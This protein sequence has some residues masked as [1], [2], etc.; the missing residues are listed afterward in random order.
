MGPSA[1]LFLSV[2]CCA[3]RAQSGGDSAAPGKLSPEEVA[4]RVG[5][6]LSQDPQFPAWYV[7]RRVRFIEQS[8]ALRNSG[9]ATPEQV[10]S[11][12]RYFKDCL[13]QWNVINELRVTPP[14]P[15]HD[16]LAARE[17]RLTKVIEKD[18]D[19][20]GDIEPALYHTGH[21]KK[22]DPEAPSAPPTETPI[23]AVN[24]DGHVVAPTPEVVSPQTSGVTTNSNDSDAVADPLQT[25]NKA[26]FDLKHGMTAGAASAY[27]Q[28]LASDPANSAA[29]SGLSS[30]LFKEGNFT[31]AADAAAQALKLDPS[32]Q[33]ALAV[34]HLS[35]DRTSPPLAAAAPAFGDQGAA[36][37]VPTGAVSARAAA[38]AAVA[39]SGA[40]PG[41]SS[42]SA[43]REARTAVGL[44]DL[45][46]ALSIL[47]RALDRRPDDAALLAARAQVCVLRREYARAEADARAALASAP[48]DAGAL[49]A[50]GLS[51]L[52][53][54][55]YAGADETAEALITFHPRDAFGYALRA[56]ARGSAGDRAGMLADLKRAAALDPYYAPALARL[57]APLE[58]PTERDLLFLF[59]GEPERRPAPPSPRGRGYAVPLAL[60]AG[61][62]LGALLA[63]ALLSLKRKPAPK[64]APPLFTRREGA[65]GGAAGAVAGPASPVLIAGQYE[66]SRQIGEGGM[67]TVYSGVD[68]LLK[69]P[70]AIKKMREELRHNPQ[71]RARFVIEAK[72]V[73]ALH[74]PAIVDIY[75]IAE[76]GP[77]LYLI[78]E[79]ID[80]KTV[81]ELV[82]AE[83]R[84]SLAET[85]RATRAA[86]DALDFAHAHG[87]VHRDM[88]P[89]NMMRDASGRVKVMDFGIARMVKDSLTR[90]SMTNNVIGTPPYMAPE[91]EQGHVRRE[92]DVYA[93]A[94]CAYEMTTGKLPFLGV[95][96]G[97]LMNKLRMSYV[98]PSRAIAGLPEALDAVYA[99]A[100]QADPDRRCRTPKEFADALESVPSGAARTRRATP[101]NLAP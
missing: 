49:R 74:H 95:G 100:F 81:H 22:V 3:A 16:A 1:Y 92:S 44:K 53:L 82:Q 36:G 84:L 31:A 12:V 46:S 76:H 91:Q 23:P 51:Q 77:D 80:G 47:D 41:G 59:P 55:D 63:L 97:M 19:G 26:N 29:L 54:K 6:E 94:V 89:S 45:D 15:Q 52:R 56:H 83:G 93:L 43:L 24:D 39:A 57:G 8:A 85:A 14:G 90:H 98:P 25:F 78:F 87:V 72:T 65:T 48:S 71:E 101:T 17:A 38:A 70:V 60:G 64:R 13:P 11:A 79:F 2:L 18:L 32:D 10:E 33:N 58:L 4:Q 34:L 7:Q 99:K 67:G 66:I 9:G 21:L 88:K 5:A 40:A 28:I 20:S 37:A 69:R 50:L 86:A 75:A 61:G 96:A 62:V 35:Q 68:R 42:A 30:V 73:A 27:R